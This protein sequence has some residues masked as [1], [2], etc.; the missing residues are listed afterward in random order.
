MEKE[1]LFIRMATSMKAFLSMEKLKGMV[2]TFKKVAKYT[3]VI[4]RMI[5]LTATVYRELG[6]GPTMK[7]NFE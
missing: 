2:F 7:V 4:G 5:N 3:K 6:M 1:S